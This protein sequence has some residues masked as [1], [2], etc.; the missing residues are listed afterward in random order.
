MCLIVNQ[1]RKFGIFSL[2]LT[3][4][5]I[6]S[7]S[8]TIPAMV[9]ALSVKIV[10]FTLTGATIRAAKHA[11]ISALIEEGHKTADTEKVKF[12]LLAQIQATPI[13]SIKVESRLSEL[14]V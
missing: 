12:S 4:S 3:E 11:N 1:I 6:I 8:L 9:A 14:S 10:I 2:F 5:C 7:L 13:E